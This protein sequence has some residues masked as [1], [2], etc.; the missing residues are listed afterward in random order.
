MDRLLKV[1]PH[2]FFSRSVDMPD[3]HIDPKNI[4]CI[5]LPNLVV[6]VN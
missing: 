5:P 4:V 3:L 2:L 6:E 1:N